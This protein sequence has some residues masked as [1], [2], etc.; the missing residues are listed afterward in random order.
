[1]VRASARRRTAR[2]F[3]FRYTIKLYRYRVIARIVTPMEFTRGLHGRYWNQSNNSRSADRER[4][5][6]STAIYAAIK[7]RRLAATGQRGQPRFT[8]PAASVPP[9]IILSVPLCF[10]IYRSRATE[11]PEVPSFPVLVSFLS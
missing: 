1:M 7:M 4:P 9:W 10:A 2:L 6:F 3:R 5:R 11:F 8:Q